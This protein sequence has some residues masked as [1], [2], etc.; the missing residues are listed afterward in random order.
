MWCRLG[1]AKVFNRREDV[2]FMI[3]VSGAI[4]WME[5]S[6]YSGRKRMEAEGMSEQEI[7]VAERVADG[8]NALIQSDAS[9]EAY[10]DHISGDPDAQP[11]SEAFWG[12][13]KRNWR[14]DLRNIGVLETSII[15]HVLASI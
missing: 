1:H 7:E 11:M 4:N 13:A 6:R 15:W 2:A 9:Y 12:F 14:A 10:L 5:Q 8:I 3:S